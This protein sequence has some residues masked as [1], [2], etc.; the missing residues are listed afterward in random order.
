MTGS[1]TYLVIQECAQLANSTLYCRG[2]LKNYSYQCCKSVSRSCGSAIN[3][4][5]GSGYGS[6][7]LQF[8]K[9]SKTFNI[10]LITDLLPI[11]QH[12][13]QS[14]WP[15]KCSVGSRSV[16]KLPIRS[17]NRKNYLRILNTNSNNML[18]GNFFCAWRF[19]NFWNSITDV[20]KDYA[21]WP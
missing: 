14:Q 15:P 20:P 10:F 1:E 13:C 2:T 5:P 11:W 8:I 12:I 17:R 4:P 16:I 6:G 18:I 19:I 7:S 9:D 3:W 21:A